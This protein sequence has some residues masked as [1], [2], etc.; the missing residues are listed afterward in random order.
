MKL[1]QK[2]PFGKEALTVPVAR[3][4]PGIRVWPSDIVLI[5]K[6]IEKMRS[7]VVASCRS[8]PFTR[9]SIRN[10]LSN[11]DAGT[12][13]G[14]CIQH[15]MIRKDYKTWEVPYHW[16]KCIWAFAD[17]KLFVIPLPLSRR[18]VVNDG[19]SPNMIHSV[20]LCDSEPCLPDNH[21]D[22]AFIVRCL[23][24]GAM[25]KDLFSVSNDGCESFCKDNR[26]RGLVH[27]IAAVETT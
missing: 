8:S 9:I 23:R 26:M 22:L 13:N 20:L 17:I 3:T 24:E 4:S 12:A 6:V 2:R 16:A 27:F 1:Q 5:K 19:V 11:S 15:S 10:T 18:H 21:G 25:W 14:P 7:S